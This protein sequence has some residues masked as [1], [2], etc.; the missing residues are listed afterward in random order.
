MAFRKIFY[1]ENLKSLSKKTSPR[2]FYHLQAT[3]MHMDVNLS[4]GHV[5]SLLTKKLFY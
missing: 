1:E 2:L 4:T 3:W 5:W